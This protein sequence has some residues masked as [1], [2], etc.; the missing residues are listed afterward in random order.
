MIGNVLITGVSSGIGWGLAREYLTKG[1]QVYGLSRRRPKEFIESPSFHFESIDLIESD[2]VPEGLKRLLGDLVHLDLVILNAG[3][4]GRVADM[5]EITT[6]ELR[7][8]LEINLVANKVMIDA[9][10]GLGL[11][12]QQ[13]VAISSGAAT[14]P[15]R[16]WNAYAISKAAL[17]MMIGLYAVER[18]ETHF[19]ALAPGIVD[20]PMQDQIF[21][22]PRDER[23]SSLDMLRNAK[24]SPMMPKPD[25][26][27][28]R[29][30][31]GIMG[32]RKYPSGS[33]LDINSLVKRDW[34][35]RTG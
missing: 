26:A 11:P 30:V 29:L 20:T 13:I 24:G 34:R 16:G 2:K 35:S 5:E 33:F 9:L 15:N 4:L 3:V 19:C 27:A 28:A 18:A 12:I 31:D 6:D 22:V 21:D 17:N 14:A 8:V 1:I 7:T 32:A 25:V 23:F 10:F